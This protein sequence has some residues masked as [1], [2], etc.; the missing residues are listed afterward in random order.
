MSRR[1]RA[2]SVL[3]E[4]APVIAPSML[5]CDFARLAD[6]V[7]LLDEANARAL[8][9]DVMD[10]RFVPNLSYGAMVITALRSRTEAV[11]DAH[12]MIDEPAKYV[13][14][15]LDAGCDV[16]T[17]H[18]E[19]EDFSPELLDRIR[20]ADVAAGVCLNPETPVERL[21]PLLG[22]FDLALVMSVNPGFGGQS[23]LP[24]SDEK[25]AATFQAA[26]DAIVG[27]DGGVG[28]ETIG[29]ASAAGASYFV[30]GSSIFDREDYGTAV[31]QLAQT[32]SDA[33]ANR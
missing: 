4:S 18:V 7:D 14:E 33:R 10:G 13:D 9:W 8:H 1:E 12:L 2:L 3:R 17:V 16:V 25:L 30:C 26:G 23:Y 21:E 20:E 27:V 6:E 32:A 15:Y 5:K 19:A 24:G 29:N 11:F 22:Q 31:K 28:A